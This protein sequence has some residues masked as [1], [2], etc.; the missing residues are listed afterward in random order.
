[1]G[2]LDIFQPRQ[3]IAQVTTAQQQQP[4]QQQQQQQQPA[5]PGTPG[6]PA[7]AA[8]A[9]PSATPT[10]GDP[11]ALQAGKQPGG[12]SPL[13]NFT[14]LWK[15]EDEDKPQDF[16]AAMSPN[17]NIDP[18]AVAT[19]AKSVDYAKLVPPDVITKALSGD[20]TAFAEVLNAVTQ[21]ATANAGMNSARIVE[22]ALAHQ[23]QKFA[24]LLPSEVRKSQI[25]M[26]VNQDHPIF[27]NPAAAPLIDSLKN[28]FAVKYPT[29]TAQQI[30][31]FTSNYLTDFVK[32]VGG[33]MP[34]NVASSTVAGAKT[35][36]ATDWNK[37][38]G[39]K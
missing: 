34:T 39:L 30:S 37:Y 32:A 27:Q 28:Q 13:A 3:P 5:A 18:K 14:E 35:E 38:F 26:Q 16:V 22:A 7:V 2:I 1:M 12:E 15:I 9:G 6:N 29:A 4:Q 23:A 11:S 24:E 20:T 19:A 10:S 33:T 25:S 17:F 31:D 21:A 8:P 36:T